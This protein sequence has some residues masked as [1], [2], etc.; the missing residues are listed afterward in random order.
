MKN[1]KFHRS[2]LYSI[3]LSGELVLT[4]LTMLIRDHSLSYFALTDALGLVGLICLVAG[5]ILLIIQGGFFDGIIYSFRRF[6]RSWRQKQLGESDSEA[7]MAEYKIRDGSHW[8]VT[9]PMLIVSLIIILISLFL[10]LA[11]L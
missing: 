1:K 7:P 2:I 5:L 8:P 6:S 10:S 4:F 9:W 11:L 3:I